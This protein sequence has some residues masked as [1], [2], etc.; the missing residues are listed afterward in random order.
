MMDYQGSGNAPLGVNA[1]RSY[2]DNHWLSESSGLPCAFIPNYIM[3]YPVCRRIIFYL[4]RL[5]RWDSAFV[6]SDLDYHCI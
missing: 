3:L 5:T 1:N 4:P 2:Q 6:V